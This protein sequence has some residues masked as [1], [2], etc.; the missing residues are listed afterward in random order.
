VRALHPDTRATQQSALQPADEQLQR[1]LAAYA[2]LRDPERRARYDRETARYN[3]S[4]ASGT[5]SPPRTRPVSTSSA[6]S[7][8]RVRIFGLTLD[9]TI[10]PLAD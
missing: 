2:L 4:A 3:R 7:G 5:S 9:L 6:S 10:N 1:V 8:V